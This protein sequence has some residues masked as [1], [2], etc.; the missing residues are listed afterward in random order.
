MT[1]G[2]V[3]PGYKEKKAN[4]EWENVPKF[5]LKEQEKREDK[6]YFKHALNY[7]LS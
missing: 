5:S 3:M 2:F 1:L 6:T 7:S 4:N